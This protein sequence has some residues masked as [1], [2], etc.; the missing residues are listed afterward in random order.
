MFYFLPVGSFT[1]IVFLDT[2]HGHTGGAPPPGVFL[3]LYGITH[4]V[5]HS[6]PST[7]LLAFTSCG[8]LA[9]TLSSE[10]YI[11][12]AMSNILNW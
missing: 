12:L 2:S 10:A 7:V 6:H 9:R 8:A 4:R 1:L 11:L 3:S 5:Q